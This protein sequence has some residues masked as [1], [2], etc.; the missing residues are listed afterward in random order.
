[1]SRGRRYETE[2]KLN[3]QK[4]FAVIIAIIVIAMVVMIIKNVFAQREKLN[5]EYEYFTAFSADKWG[6]INQDGETVI[7]PSYQEMIV[8]PDK[9]KDVFICTYDINEEDGTYKTKVLNRKNEE[10]FTQYDQIQVLENIDEN[11]NIWYE[12]N[13]LKVMQNGKYGLIDLN[14]KKLLDCEYDEISAM[15]GIENSLLIRKDGYVGLANNAGTILIDVKYS[16][17][18][19]LGTT[20]KEGYIT[21]DENGK[22]GIVST[23]KIQIL[24]N[25]YNEIK[26]VYLG[27]N[28]YVVEDGE[29]KIINQAGETLIDKGFDDIKSSTK[30]GIIFTQKDLYGE[31]TTSGDILI[32]AKYKDLKEAKGY[33]LDTEVTAEELKDLVKKFKDYYKQTFGEDFPSD[34]YVQRHAAAASPGTGSGRCRADPPGNFLRVHRRRRAYQSQPDQASDAEQNG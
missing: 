20:Y 5:K 22:C 32:E 33:K 8:I 18:K 17:I 19:N 34:P 7:N 25:K 29:E 3:Y 16:D 9:T 21:T 26:Q 12:K 30:R 24:E 27:D 1:M 28:Y 15:K 11:D 23:T 4:V 13:V 31:M 6:V 14:G 10:I 2:G